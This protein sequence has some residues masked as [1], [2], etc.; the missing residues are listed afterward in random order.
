MST[1]GRLHCQ[2]TGG[3][4]CGWGQWLGKGFF[5]DQGEDPSLGIQL[6]S[7]LYRKYVT[8]IFLSL[9]YKLQK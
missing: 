5:I 7:I 2:G 4:G 1:Q 8:F 9:M 6:S 3:T